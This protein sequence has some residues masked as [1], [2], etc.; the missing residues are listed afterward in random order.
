MKLLK[1]GI[2]V[3][4][5]S[6]LIF[7]VECY[8]SD[9]EDI[10][11]KGYVTGPNAAGQTVTEYDSCREGDSGYGGD[12]SGEYV[13]EQT[14]EI[15]SNGAFIGKYI[16]CP[17]D[18]YCYD[19]ACKPLDE[20]EEPEEEEGR[21]CQST[22][23]NLGKNIYEKGTTTQWTA[24]GSFLDSETDYCRDS[25]T[26]VDYYCSRGEIEFTYEDCPS[27]Y[28]CEDG[29]CKSLDGEDE[30]T[31][32]VSYTLMDVDDCR[33][34]YVVNREIKEV[35]YGEEIEKNIGGPEGYSSFLVDF[36]GGA[37]VD[38]K[39]L[40]KTTIYGNIDWYIEDGFEVYL[41]SR[42][43]SHI[44]LTEI[45]RDY[46]TF[47]ING[48]S[49]TIDK[50]DYLDLSVGYDGAYIDVEDV[51]SDKC[52]IHVHPDEMWLLEDSEG[53]S[54]EVTTVYPP[55]ST[56]YV[57]YFDLSVEGIECGEEEVFVEVE[58]VEEEVIEIEPVEEEEATQHYSVALNKGWNLVSSP[59]KMSSSMTARA[60]IRN[61]TCEG[62]K[63]FMY[64]SNSNKY[65]IYTL[66]TGEYIPTPYAF[67]AKVDSFCLLI[68]EGNYH[69]SYD[70]GLNVPR[71]WVAL[72]APMKKTNW[73]DIKGDCVA[74]SGPWDFDT[75]EWTWKR[76]TEFRP[77]KG[78]FVKTSGSC[79]LGGESP[80]PLPG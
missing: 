33:C 8:D 74:A 80:P 31:E 59:L 30:S 15:Y 67:W 69:V 2:L 25:S 20:E 17:L 70:D 53:L 63:A 10:Y 11:N 14:C 34:Q 29:A 57:N 44:I 68:F 66:S 23:P 48:E 46:C 52:K 1:F 18:Y 65:D 9:N 79:T 13:F 61:T 27:D 45:G 42:P 60:R 22:D 49:V 36:T 55:T 37:K 39:V 73:D 19:G 6:G 24:Q 58:P 28:V 64:D 76:A 26:V 43:T 51:A 77:T 72:G 4:I 12:E 21:V 41:G 47:L 16:K 56:R 38:G 54:V 62:I 40:C 32:E 5:L 75:S 50:G 3:L 78:Y 7:S 35:P 71:G